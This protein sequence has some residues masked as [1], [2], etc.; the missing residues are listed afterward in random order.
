[1]LTEHNSLQG[2]DFTSHH[3][4]PAPT[5]PAVIVAMYSLMD[6]KQAMILSLNIMLTNLIVHGQSLVM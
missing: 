3:L 4:L 1:M 2:P 5:I 6:G